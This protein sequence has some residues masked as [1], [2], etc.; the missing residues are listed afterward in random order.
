MM[1]KAAHEAVLQYTMHGYEVVSPGSFVTCF[2][3]GRRIPLE[4]LRYWNAERQEAYATPDAGLE[5][6]LECRGE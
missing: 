1:D 6:E 2:V 3:T 5:R 4:D